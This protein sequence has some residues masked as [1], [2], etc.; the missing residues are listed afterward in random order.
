M[1]NEVKS[2][3]LEGHSPNEAALVDAHGV[4]IRLSRWGVGAFV[5]LAVLITGFLLL[6]MS[7][8]EAVVFITTLSGR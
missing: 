3:D 8:E 2:I 1:V 4:K 5:V 7:P 6:W